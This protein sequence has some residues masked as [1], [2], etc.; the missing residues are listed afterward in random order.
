MKNFFTNLA[1]GIGLL[2]MSAPVFAQDNLLAEKPIYPLGEAKTWTSSNEGGE[3]Y[4]FVTEDLEKLV[5]VPVNTSNV[6][7]F[8]ET[9]G[10]WNNDANK[11]IGIQGFYVDLESVQEIGTVSTTWEGAAA[12]AYS[13]YLTETEPTPAILDETPVYSASNLG[14]YTENTAVLPEG[15]KGR[16]LVFQPTDAT[17]WGW[18][19]K[20]R[21]IAATAPADDILTTFKV[22]P[23]IVVSGEET[24]VSFTILNQFGLDIPQ[25]NVEILVSD[26]ATYSDGVFI[27]NSGSKATFTATL[28]GETIEA[29]IYAA[30]AP[31]V[32]A[33]TSIKTPIYTNTSSDYNSTVEFTTAYN[34]GA[35]NMGE[36]AFPDGEVARQFADTRCVFFS[37]SVTTGAWN[38]NINPAEEGYRNLCLDV[39]SAGDVEC[40][41]EFESVENLEGGHTYPFSLTA[42]E[43]TPI[44][45]DVAGA[46]KLG[47]L[48]IRFTEANMT[49]ILL[50]NIYFS[51]AYVEGDEEAPVIGEVTA[52][53]SMTSIAL[54]MSATDNLSEDIYYSISDGTKTYAV[55]G[56]SG[57]TVDYTISGLQPST[58][59][60][61][62]I[63]AS[64]G[65]NVSEVR[66]I[67]V[68][69]TGMPDAE[70]PTVQESNVAVIYSTGYE[71]TELP[72]FDAWGSK[73]TMGTTATENGNQVLLFSN[74]DG[75]WGGIVNL[76]LDVTNAKTLNVSIFGD[77]AG[78]VKIAPVWWLADGN[79]TPGAVL[80]ISNSQ[81]NTWVNYSIPVT[82]LGYG[83]YST[84]VNQI[85]LTESTLPSF[86]ID[87]LYFAG[88]SALAVNDAIASD[89]DE[90]VNVYNMQ[91]ICVKSGVNAKSATDL[92]PSGLY[93]IGGSKVMV[94]K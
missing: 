74:Y 18:G 45:V 86:A 66:N 75:Q 13:I 9:G 94:R 90:I 72:A 52:T 41:I 80:E 46:T 31:E 30:T 10:G 25:D 44:T 73:A 32:P 88:D 21:S 81:I 54:S 17:N 84:T 20:I 26:N 91:G 87:N 71:I 6:F 3:T 7:L 78:K 82:D 48:S 55:N 79:E 49:D 4:T 85:A 65:K 28:G 1:V 14:Q 67:E 92:L 23:A 64:D 57:E 63:T 93:I 42:G 2:S 22:S 11:A 77:T 37:N 12:N 53:P 27:I 76:E 43:W 40:T 5:A 58:T 61:L 69:T 19:V 68:A 51:P 59:Y 33:A 36:L 38:G 29:S 56:K 39:F 35:V 62:A 8:P 60:N 47:N 34:G 89:T 70:K 16:Y 15:S 50:A 83:V 24:A